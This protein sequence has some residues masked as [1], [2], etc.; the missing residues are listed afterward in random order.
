M[1]ILAMRNL[2]VEVY[3]SHN[4]EG[5]RSQKLFQHLGT[6][7]CFRED[8][9]ECPSERS[10]SGNAGLQ[11]FRSLWRHKRAVTDAPQQSELGSL[12]TSWVT[13]PAGWTAL[14]GK[15]K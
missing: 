2:L 6:E 13:W 12:L 11:L 10:S 8:G 1:N 5:W 7:A 9:G 15:R 14:V 4:P 3:L